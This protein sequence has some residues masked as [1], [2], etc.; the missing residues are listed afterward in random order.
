MPHILLCSSGLGGMLL[1]CC[2]AGNTGLALRMS[3]YGGEARLE[4]RQVQRKV[5]KTL[6][7]ENELRAHPGS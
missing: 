7:G 3:W 6:M 2:R 4:S 5:A 1:Q